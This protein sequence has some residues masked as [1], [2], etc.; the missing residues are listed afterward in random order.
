MEII[1]PLKFIHSIQFRI[2]FSLQDCQHLVQGYFKYSSQKNAAP[3]CLERELRYFQLPVF[4]YLNDS[5]EISDEYKTSFGRRN[6]FSFKQP[7]YEQLL[8][9][10]CSNTSIRSLV[11]IYTK[12]SEI[13]GKPSAVF[14]NWDHLKLLKVKHH[15]FCV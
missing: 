6:Y 10:Q 4:L 13:V 5:A 2:Y 3:S 8:G 7:T 11:H 9:I 12:S 1:C 14:H 15:L